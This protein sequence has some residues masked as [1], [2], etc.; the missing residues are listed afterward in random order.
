MSHR[1]IPYHDVIMRGDS[2]TAAAVCLPEG[3]ALRAYRAGDGEHWARL[4]HAVGDFETRQAAAAYFSRH[5]SGAEQALEQRMTLA[6]APDGAVVGA[7]MA[8]RE[9]RGEESASFVHWLVVDPAHQ[10]K[11]LGRALLVR[12]LH[13]FRE[14]GEYDIFLHTQPWSFRAI[15]LY[16]S[17]GFH[18][19]RRT[20]FLG[21]KNEYEPAIAALERVLPAA[22][23]DRLAAHAQD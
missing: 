21:K 20:T 5:F 19:L 6:L 23:M 9:T 16:D 10:G 18:M 22:A 8:W 2:R 4:E 12:T 15:M 17:L 14:L 3:Y 7:C 1:T 13:I 11:G